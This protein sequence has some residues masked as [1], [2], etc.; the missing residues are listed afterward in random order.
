M[1]AQ[2]TATAIKISAPASWKKALAEVHEARG[3]V[4][5]VEDDE[6]AEAR[7]AIGRDGVGC[8]PASAASLAGLKKLVRA[9]TIA[10]GEDIVLVLTGHLLKDSAYAAHY[11]ESSAPL[12]NHIL[13]GVAPA[14]V[15][16]ELTARA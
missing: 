5:D 4:D 7:A 15:I 14:S 8:E 9:G 13:R 6:I 2:T 3:T 11:H 10:P 16:D 12:A 1:Q